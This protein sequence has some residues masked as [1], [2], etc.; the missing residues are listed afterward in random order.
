MQPCLVPILSYAHC[1]G[2]QVKVVA[3][4]NYIKRD[5]GLIYRDFE[6]G[7]GDCPKDGQQVFLSHFSYICCV[8]SNLNFTCGTIIL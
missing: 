1:S 5:S 3:S 4:D 6:V 2:F 7:Q 8:I